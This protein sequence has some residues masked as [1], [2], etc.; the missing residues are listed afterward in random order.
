MRHAARLRPGAQV[1]DLACGSG[2]HARALAALGCRVDAIDRDPQCMASLQGIEGIRFDCSDL[3]TEH[4][5]VVADRYDAIVV[6]NYLYRPRLLQLASS[7]RDGGLLLYE[8]FAAGNER[9]GRPS[10][11]D[12]LLSP[13]ELARTFAPV[14]HV[15]AFEDGV[16]LAPAPARIQRLCA[17]RTD[18]A[19]QDR[20][21][22][23]G[24]V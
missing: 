20:L 13:F 6:A 3:E 10:H 14:L 23:P 12:Y 2:R 4:W 9:F 5:P 24:A 21:T 17:I 22:L 11:P 16:V 7:L 15:L 19:R 18:V 1:L 8:T